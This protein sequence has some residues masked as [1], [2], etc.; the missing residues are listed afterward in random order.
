MVPTTHRMVAVCAL[1][2]AGAVHAA[3]PVDD[4]RVGGVP[5]Y[6]AQWRA[7]TFSVSTQGE[8]ALDAD[9]SG[10]IVVVWSSRRQ[11]S[12]RYG[13]YGQQLGPDGTSIGAETCLNLWTDSHQQAPDVALAP[14]GSGWVV[15]QSHGQ[16]GDGGSIIARKFDADLVGGSEVLVNGVTAGHQSDPSI[17]IL[18]GG[19]AVV[20]WVSTQT[21]GVP[22]VRARLLG[23]GGTPDG[24]ELPVGAASGSARSPA[25]AAGDDGAFAVAYSSL[26]PDGRPVGIM[27][28]RFDGEGRRLGEPTTVSSADDRGPVE[29]AVAAGAGSIIV[30]WHDPIHN[31]GYG[32]FVRRLD[33]SGCPIGEPIQVADGAWGAQSGAAVAVDSTGRFAVAFNR[34]A[35]DTAGVLA[36]IFGPDGVPAGPCFRL[37]GP[38]A[39]RQALR[40]AAGSRRLV[41][42]PDGTLLAAWSGDGGFGD[43][44]AAGVT[45]LSPRR[46]V[47][48]AGAATAVEPRPRLAAA[49]H[50][51][52]TFD[53]HQ[54][55]IGRR[56][57]LAAG[58]SI[59]FTGIFNTGWTPPDPHMAV[60]PNH[61]VLMTNGE[62]A[63]LTK[64][65]T[66]VFQ[67][68]IEGAG[69]FWG[70]VGATGF[71]FDPEV[72]FDALTGR[73]FAMAAEGYAPGD[74]S[75]VLVAVS[76]DSN[77]DGAW[78]KYRFETTALA[79]DVFDSPNIGVD[80]DAVY[81]TGD[82][83]GRGDVYAV[84]VFD[85]VALLAGLPTAAVNT[86]TIPSSTLSAGI[87]PVSFDDP[88]A[89]Y[90]IEHG[91]SPN[92]TT[93]RLIALQDGLGSPSVTAMTLVVPAY[94]RPEDPPQM[95]T[96]VRPETFDARFWSVA[97]RKG[98]LWAT[99]HVN[100]D[101][102]LARWYQIDMNDWPESGR[103]PVLVQSG[104][105]DPG[106]G[107]RTFFSAITV[108]EHGNAAMAFARSSPGEFIS[109]ATAFRYATDPPG[110]FGSAD[111]RQTSTGPYLNARWGD[112][113]AVG[114][115][116]SDGVTFWAH[117]EYAEASSWRTWV[118]GVTPPF[119][120]ADINHDGAVTTTDL[121]ILL[122]AWGPCPS[123]PAGC[124]AD[125]D[126]DGSVT[127]TDLLALLAAWG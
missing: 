41:F 57:T 116:P 32:T 119:D 29:P 13:V 105:I 12:G 66:P 100:S 71:V 34:S 106:P 118:A 47:A 99:H 21:G 103:D 39:S 46:P 89:L 33:R 72:I 54:I 60:G 28:Q 65:G 53:R 37:T 2:A 62:I 88:P 112:Y 3:E 87:P 78:S 23:P 52:P 126:G 30:A 79:G 4:V 125:I 122:G 35:Q 6:A 98:S 45:A 109:M 26:D 49:P 11:Q 1:L 55:E 108:D 83:V 84:Y 8:A 67:D 90:M 36:R 63:F 44:S 38:L 48:A 74:R 56:R 31:G 93:V 61:V 85:K 27:L 107:I 95:G 76:D 51:P 59:G 81:V 80:A 117:H 94:G 82:A 115:D 120:P 86:L 111:I 43:R 9:G 69:G 14:D 40:P 70:A 75:Y 42:G 73:Y 18:P 124:P 96:T 101:R 15:W 92:N 64:D 97:Y 123:P 77:P 25:V 22:R 20:A 58:G 127:V 110:T 91:E 10:R 102:V 17:A 7:S 16:D 68:Q 50:E 24:A 19:T 121:L 5:L 114:V 104:Q 113:G